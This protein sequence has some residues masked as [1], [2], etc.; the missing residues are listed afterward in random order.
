MQSANALAF[1]LF[2]LFVNRLEDLMQAL[3][4]LLG[5]GLMGLKRLLQLRTGTFFR[6][7]AQSFDQLLL[8]VQ[9]VLQFVNE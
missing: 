1:D 5:L 2:S 8:G 9:H 7:F 6:L 3:N 4:L